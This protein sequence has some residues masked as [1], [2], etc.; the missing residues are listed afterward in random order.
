MHITIDTR[1]KCDEAVQY[2]NSK[3]ISYSIEQLKY[4]DYILNNRIVFERKTLVDFVQSVK[5]GR[6]FRQT[7]SRANIDKPYILILEGNKGTLSGSN[8]KREA[9][10][11]ALVHIAVFMGIPVLRAQNYMETLQ[12]IVAAGMQEEK[13]DAVNVKQIYLRQ[14]KGRKA[15]GKTEKIRLLQSLPGIGKSRANDL[16]TEFGSVKN[17]MLA[18]EDDL[19]R[20]R[21]I[22]KG[23]AIQIKRV[24]E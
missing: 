21:G 1:E 8:M 5:D 11:G 23:T 16:L 13:Y 6:L 18:S 2:L 9:V 15:K 19:C 24:F 20:V 10:Q 14:P 4:G 3:N 7:Y 22:G 17:I 12:L